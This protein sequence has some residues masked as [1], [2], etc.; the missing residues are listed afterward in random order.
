VKKLLILPALVLGMSAIGSAA[1]IVN[2][3]SGPVAGVWTWNASLELGSEVRTGDFFTIY[4]L[5][6]FDDTSAH[7]EQAGWVETAALTGVTPNLTNPFDDPATFNVTWTYVGTP[8]IPPGTNIGNFTITSTATTSRLDSY[9]VSSHAPTDT[10]NPGTQQNVGQ[11]TVPGQAV[12]ATPE[13]S[14][15]IL[16]GGGLTAFG[17]WMRRRRA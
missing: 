16:F 9:A 8:T 17:L 13:P 7:S 6:G 15:V 3:V 2:F 11:T 4:D 14:S 1:I 12:T 5:G 10:G